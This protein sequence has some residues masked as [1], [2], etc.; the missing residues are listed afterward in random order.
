MAKKGKR[1]I[2]N[3]ACTVCKTQNYVSEKN[4]LNNPERLE[5]N[6][7]CPVCKK[8]TLHREVR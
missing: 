8:V 2:I 1:N 3:L 7:F 4:K 6:K 5:F